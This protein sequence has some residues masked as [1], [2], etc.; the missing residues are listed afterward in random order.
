MR[1]C[2]EGAVQA[3]VPRP[4]P[5]PAACGI[6]PGVTSFNLLAFKAGRAECST[7]LCRGALLSDPETPREALGLGSALPCPP[8]GLAAGGLVL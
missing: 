2:K 3:L 7:L 8:C 6:F 1:G 4:S 5:A